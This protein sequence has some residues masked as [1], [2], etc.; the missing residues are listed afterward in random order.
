M[1][2]VFDTVSRGLLLI[3]IGIIFFLLN[4]GFLSWSLWAYVVDLWPLI[5]ILAGIGLLLN[6]RIPLSAILLVFL[7]SIIGYSIVMG[8]KSAPGHMVSPYSRGST[9][10]ESIKVPL[11]ADV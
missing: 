7:L 3:T 8:D 6:R 5:L 11:P 10:T 4:Y 9:E 2:K 1:K